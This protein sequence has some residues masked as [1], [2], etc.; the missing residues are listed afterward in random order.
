MNDYGSR[1]DL[2]LV[3]GLPVGQP[4]GH[5]CSAAF[6]ALPASA[7]WQGSSSDGTLGLGSGAGSTG[8]GGPPGSVWVAAS[9]IWKQQ[10]GSDHC[11]VYADFACIGGAFPCSARGG[12]LAA[13][14]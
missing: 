1:I 10:E 8:S 6:A 2:I 5:G 14:A 13:C 12:W 3:A 7:R 4:P 11:P 9:E